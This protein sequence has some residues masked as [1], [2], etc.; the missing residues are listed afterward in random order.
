MH[1]EL[2]PPRGQRHDYQVRFPLNTQSLLRNWWQH[3]D[4]PGWRNF[5][6]GMAALGLALLLALYSAAAAESGQSS[7]A[8]VSAVLALI[9]AGWVAITIV[10][11]LAR[12]TAL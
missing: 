11:A 4:R 7:L 5:A 9:L 10:P 1:S 6:I 2:E 12:R 8:A 3:L